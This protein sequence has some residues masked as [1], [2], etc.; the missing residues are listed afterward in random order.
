MNKSFRKTLSVFA[1][2]LLLC[3]LMSVFFTAAASDD[4]AIE[5][6]SVEKVTLIKN[7]D[8]DTYD[9]DGV[10]YFHYYTDYPSDVTV[11]FVNG[12]SMTGSFYELESYFG[13][14]AEFSDSQS[15]QN[16]W[17]TGSYKA[18][19]SFM[20]FEGEYTVEITETPVEKIVVA[21]KNLYY[22]GDGYYDVFSDNSDIFYY[23][24][25]P[26]E[27]TVYFKDGSVIS[28]TA[29]SFYELTGYSVNVTDSQYESPWT[30]GRYKCRAEYMGVTADYYAN[31]S[32]SPVK[33]IMVDSLTLYEGI[34]GVYGSD[35]FIEGAD[36][37]TFY[38]DAKPEKL[39]VFYKDG[40]AFTGSVEE[41]EKET[42]YTVTYDTNKNWS[43]GKQV[44]T[45]SFLG[46]TTKYVVNVKENPIS[47]V[48]LIKAP[49]KT[50]YYAGELFDI[51]GS[52]IR[53]EYSNGKREDIEL[54]GN[55]ENEYTEVALSEINKKIT[56]DTFVEIGVNDYEVEIDFCETFFT[57]D[58]SVKDESIKA[59]S[60]VKD[61]NGFP[62]IEF[63]FTDS[64]K[65]SVRVINTVYGD[66]NNMKPG[67]YCEAILITDKGNFR[68]VMTKRLEGYALSFCTADY[69]NAI[70]TGYCEAVNWAEAAMTDKAALIYY[71][72]EG[73]DAYNGLVATDNIDRLLSFA[74]YGSSAGSPKEIHSDYY[75]Y[76]VT[77]IQKSVKDF[78]DV[79]GIDV[80][81]S[82]S[83]DAKTNTVRIKAI[84]DVNL[85]YD[86]GRWVSYPVSY[87]FND[88]YF[89]ATYKFSDG[90][91]MDVA[92]DKNGRIA[93]Y[94]V[95][96]AL[97]HKH[98]MLTVPGVAPT[99]LKTGLTD[100]V[101]CSSC[102]EILTSQQ[103]IAR[104]ILGK[105]EKIAFAHN[106]NTIKI[107]W[108]K[109]SG[110]TGY[111][112]FYK[113]PASNWKN[114]STTTATSEVF[115]NLPSGKKYTFA[116][117]AYVIESGKVIK[118]SEYITVDTATSPLKPAKVISKQNDSAIKLT[119]SVSTGATGYR[120]F[121]KTENG[122]KALG[123]TSKTTA[124][125]ANLK[126]GTR[127]IFAVRPYI[128]TGNTVVWCDSY[129]EY[130]AATLPKAPEV[131]AAAPSEGKITLSY[132]AV[133]G[134]EAY[135]VFYRT[136]NGSY[137]LYR[138]Y[139][140]AGTLNFTSLKSGTR[141]EFAVRAAKRT[142]GGWIFGTYNSAIV[143]VK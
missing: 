123:H 110:A 31:V 105:A 14:D 41:I 22:R 84:E 98:V 101:K 39:T 89:K 69:E 18:F 28:G 86:L 42:G 63:T 16:P 125:F 35:A 96:D 55:F 66:F 21:E 50:E 33:S 117:R 44:G 23:Y 80:A 90:K 30:T 74:A 60:L 82:K 135:Q 124:M 45:A 10:S 6:I 130:V 91:T 122:W 9:E 99:Y 34:D 2:A 75:V 139:T 32:L 81:L 53:V 115:G 116:V 37:Q 111:E 112:V 114:C 138:N 8:G 38:Y 27:M 26:E 3:V 131:K 46:A 97:V 79:D 1:L 71:N 134:A 78:F 95:N 20:G 140:K 143:T 121:Y 108:S 128:I 68:V 107:S 49:D 87:V 59:A 67:E 141:Y 70:T 109:V 61:S 77:E 51:T 106:S 88:G 4:Y 56:L 62:V 83:F 103:T 102:G 118:A 104:L 72:Y 15:S 120:V 93:S 126:A 65:A 73:I 136:G 48:T 113:T 129:T 58:I 47:D 52:V 137:K 142:S 7:Y 100:G 24:S 76:T 17:T 92:A 64:S 57:V 25:E 85:A 119:W 5:S 19:Y 13:E 36:P 29:E 127:Y 43:Y 94:R 12:K 11:R 133:S 40:S 54:Y 132:S